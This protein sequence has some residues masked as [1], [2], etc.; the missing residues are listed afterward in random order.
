MASE[1][2]VSV[3][4]LLLLVVECWFWFCFVPH[5]LC[6][7]FKLEKLGG[8][9]VLATCSSGCGRLVTILDPGRVH[10]QL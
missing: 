1:D 8:K 6:W 3:R 7:A 9:R 4:V 2:L 10:S 5:V